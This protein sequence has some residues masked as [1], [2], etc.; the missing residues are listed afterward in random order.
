MLH[1]S[2]GTK[3]KSPGS[4]GNEKSPPALSELVEKL[5]EK[6]IIKENSSKS[7]QSMQISN[8]NHAT[9]FTVPRASLSMVQ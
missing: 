3:G 1:K 5:N 2:Q 4:G 9:Q 7:L 6:L 8:L